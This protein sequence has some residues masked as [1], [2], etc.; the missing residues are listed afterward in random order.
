MTI[1]EMRDKIRRTKDG[2]QPE[3]VACMGANTHE[4]VVSVREQLYSGIDGRDAPLSPSYENDPYFHDSHA[5]YYDE[6][7]GH[8][9]SCYLHP[10]RYIAWKMRITPPEAS[11]RLGLPA[12]QSVQPNL[13]II[14]TFHGSIDARA[15]ARGVEIFTYGWDSGPAVERKYGSQIFGLGSKAV[16]H[17]NQSFLWPWLK[18][19]YRDL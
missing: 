4:M 19:W 1:A 5:G 2:I 10:E 11:Q 3:I 17:F 18:S 16:G 13:F 9:V 7:A 15:T 8:W 14:G 12:R 6:D